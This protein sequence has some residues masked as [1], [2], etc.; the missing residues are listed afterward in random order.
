MVSFTF[1]VAYI[2]ADRITKVYNGIYQ[3]MYIEI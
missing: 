3:Y 1:F 2:I